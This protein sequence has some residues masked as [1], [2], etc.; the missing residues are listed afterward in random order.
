MGGLTARPAEIAD[1]DAIARV[2]VQAWKEAY[3]HL[4]P[5]AFLDDRD[6]GQYAERWRTIIGSGSTDVAVADLDGVVV[7]WAAAGAGR[8][9][10]APRDR[11]L[12]G[13][14]VLAAVYGSGA[15]Q[16][17]IDRAVGDA[18]AYL[19]IAEH[20][21]RAEAFYHRNGFRRDGVVKRE[22]LGPHTLDVVRMV[23]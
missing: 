5:A 14:Y 2:H 20:N 12:E 7:G 1:A 9:H 22:Q 21:P 17:L 8:D 18:P 4:L 11:E 16:A 15:G 19:W 10:D 23:R 3:A 6:V 13:I